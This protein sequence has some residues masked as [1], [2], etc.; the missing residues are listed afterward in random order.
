[1][2][3]ATLYILIAGSSELLRGLSLLESMVADGSLAELLNIQAI[4]NLDIIQSHV[5]NQPTNVDDS[6][7]RL[8]F[9][10]NR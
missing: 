5:E 2:T 1:M 9:Q 10:I 6:K 3:S 8:C 7:W 4:Y